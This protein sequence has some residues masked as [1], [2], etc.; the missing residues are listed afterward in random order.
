MV[1]EVSVGSSILTMYS[2][3]GKLEDSLK[4]FEQL[5][6]KDNISWTSMIVG[7]SE[8]GRADKA[9]QLFQEM[10][11]KEST[12]DEKILAAVLYSCSALCS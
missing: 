11:F 6:R 10:G 9:V 7:L 12:P 1:S 3:C 4:A 2:K 8:D 5:E